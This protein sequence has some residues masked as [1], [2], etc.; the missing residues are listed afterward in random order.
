MQIQTRW[1][2]AAWFV[3]LGAAQGKGL[4]RHAAP[5]SPD[6]VWFVFTSLKYVTTTHLV[7]V[8]NFGQ[9]SLWTHLFSNH[10][11]ER[12]RYLGCKKIK[13]KVRLGWAFLLH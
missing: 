2:E 1:H 9:A 11:T 4:D 8:K 13:K 6:I 12:L 5:A 10:S 3:L 7:S